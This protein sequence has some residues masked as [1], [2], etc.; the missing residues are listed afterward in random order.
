LITLPHPLVFTL[1]EGILTAQDA[2]LLFA[3][4]N[5]ITIND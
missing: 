4:I 2:V 1:G 5:G 3:T